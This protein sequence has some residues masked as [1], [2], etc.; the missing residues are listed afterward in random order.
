MSRLGALGVAAFLA[1]CGVK[2]PPRPPGVEREQT[3]PPPTPATSPASAPDPTSP[4]TP[5][6]A[7]TSTDGAPGAQPCP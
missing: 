1:G 2:A 4:P 7:P 3:P 6:S 5:T